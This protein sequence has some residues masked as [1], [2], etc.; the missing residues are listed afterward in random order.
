MALV[1]L[2]GKMVKVLTAYEIIQLADVI[3]QKESNFEVSARNLEKKWAMSGSNIIDM[4]LISATVSPLS[5]Y[6]DFKNIWDFKEC[7]QR[8]EE[9]ETGWNRMEEK[10]DEEKCLSKNIL[11]QR[12]GKK[13]SLEG[14]KSDGKGLK[15][16]E[17]E[18][19]AKKK[20]TVEEKVKKLTGRVKRRVFDQ[21][22]QGE[23]EWEELYKSLFKESDKNVVVEK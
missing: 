6:K 16:E 15:E 9:S 11:K 10:R 23:E 7:V 8:D 12:T 2:P 22:A 18:E 13:H 19:R 21:C 20:R 17:A 14:E 4:N 5:E 1:V 3:R